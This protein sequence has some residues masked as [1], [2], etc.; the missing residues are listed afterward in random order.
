MTAP[1]PV[2]RRALPASP[3]ALAPRRGRAPRVAV[4]L[5]AVWCVRNVVRAGVLRRLAAAGVD[6]VLLPLRCA[7]GAAL[8]AT[9][10]DFA[11]ASVIEPM[12]APSVTPVRG[13]GL[14]DAVL[15]SAFHRR[16][17]I[18]SFEVYRRWLER[19]LPRAAR[20]RARAVD[21]LGALARPR[22]VQRR[23]LA[24]S[25][26]LYRRGCDLASVR[27]QLRRLRPDLVWS[28]M[29]VLGAEEPYA[30][31][32][33]DLGIP[34]VASIL[35]FDNLTSRTVLRD[36]DH[37]MV[38]S[39][40]M[41][42]QLARLYPHLPADAVTVTGTPQFD[43]H[44]QPRYHWDRARTLARLGLPGDARYFVHAASHRS[45]APDEPALVA[46]LCAALSSDARLAA[47]Q[48]VVRV[49]PLERPERWSAA[50]AASGGRLRLSPA[51]DL[52]PDADGWALAGH[53][54]QARLV[55]TLAHA[56]ACLNVASTMTLDAAILDCPVVGLDL[57]GEP[58]APRGI[59]YA[60]YEAEHYAPLVASGGLRV[61]R[62]WTEALAQLR[63]ACDAPA[64]DRAARA[65]M[66][67]RECGRV[68]GEAARR[69]AACVA[70]C[71]A[72]LAPGALA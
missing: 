33:R 64:A 44:R 70:G 39:E 32:A 16:N 66:V 25:E 14:V 40:A 59:L 49:H 63:A 29:C 36:Y 26:R 6:V 62:S 7:D 3:S 54:D 68:D 17:R 10:P 58:A 38:W 60:E 69:V 11:E 43:F 37:Y 55:S 41:G 28:T 72:R 23:L 57:R 34:L 56:D 21:A 15:R 35:S 65:A 5:P 19:D 48:V 51:W 50:I 20:V 8:A 61:A 31:A 24:G 30:M 52:P 12:L 71:L 45:L 67:A 2:A 1:A 22:S 13:K 27:A 4:L 47:H 42:A 53:D 18:A 46:A 9:D